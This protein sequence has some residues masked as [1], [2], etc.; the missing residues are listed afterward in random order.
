MMF[1]FTFWFNLLSGPT[2]LNLYIAFNNVFSSFNIC[3]L[4]ACN[5]LTARAAMSKGCA[6]HVIRSGWHIDIS[7]TQYWESI[8]F[9][10]LQT[11]MLRGTNVLGYLN[12][13]ARSCTIN[14][15]DTISR[16][17]RKREARLRS[18]NGWQILL[19][20]QKKVI[21]KTFPHAFSSLKIPQKCAGS[22]GC[23][24]D[25]LHGELRTLHRSP[26]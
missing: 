15:I 6:L 10:L 11:L 5:F 3:L 25:S 9:D 16:R 26:S 22:R 24:P 18:I 8:F 7:T 14:T 4:S 13:G 21:L 12:I 19:F 1:Q 2:D 23:A 20:L 17:E